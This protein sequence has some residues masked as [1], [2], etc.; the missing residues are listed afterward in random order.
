MKTF[1]K[2][3]LVTPEIRPAIMYLH[4]VGHLPPLPV[5]RLSADL[6]AIC[7][8]CGYRGFL[9][10]YSHAMIFLVTVLPQPYNWIVFTLYKRSVRDA[11]SQN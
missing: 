6:S 4:E 10:Q 9:Q 8:L 11:Q 2:N 3:N 1:T 5:L 7:P